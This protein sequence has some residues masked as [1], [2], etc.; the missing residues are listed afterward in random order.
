MKK[1]LLNQVAY[2]S[3]L[4][5]MGMMV[6][7]FSTGFLLASNGKVQPQAHIETVDITVS[8]TV[9]DQNGDP[10]PGV[11]VSIPDT[12]IGT[13]TDLNGRYTLSVPEGSTLVF[14]FIGFESQNITVGDRS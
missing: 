12:G 6:Q 3:K 9:T 7:C 13:A 5:A 2:M 4:F 8:G 14:S 1:K 11:T 10:L